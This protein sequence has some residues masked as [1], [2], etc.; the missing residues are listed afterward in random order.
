[1]TNSEKKD[2]KA[3]AGIDIDVDYVDLTKFIDG[4]SIDSVIGNLLALRTKLHK[5]GLDTS[6]KGDTRCYIL[7]TDNE[8][9]VGVK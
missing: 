7:E 9:L 8:F 2:V 4:K 3:I 6:S 5:E 1:M